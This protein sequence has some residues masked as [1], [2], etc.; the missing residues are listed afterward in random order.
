MDFYLPLL[1][2]C[3]PQSSTTLY[4]HWIVSVS[5]LWQACCWRRNKLVE[6]LKLA[7]NIFLHLTSYFCKVYSKY[8]EPLYSKDFAEFDLRKLWEHVMFYSLLPTCCHYL[9]VGRLVF[10][11]MKN[12]HQD[13][14][15]WN[16]CLLKSFF[17]TYGKNFLPLQKPTWGRKSIIFFILGLRFLAFAFWFELLITLKQI[18]VHHWYWFA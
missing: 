7:L 15:R 13:I 18:L 16:I 11:V 2:H 3:R 12:E 14:S 1:N 6:F 4:K 17:K 5:E 9:R 8:G 10:F